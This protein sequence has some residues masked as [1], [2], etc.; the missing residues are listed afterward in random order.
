M[1]RKPWHDR[2]THTHTHTHTRKEQEREKKRDIQKT[3][4]N[5]FFFSVTLSSEVSENELKTESGLLKS[6]KPPL[7][8][9]F[10]P[11][12][13]NKQTKNQN[14][15]KINPNIKRVKKNFILTWFAFLFIS[16][17]FFFFFLLF[18]PLRL[19]LEIHTLS[20]DTSPL[21]PFLCTH[22]NIMHTHTR[23]HTHAHTHAYSSR[24]SRNLLIF[25]ANAVEFLKDHRHNSTHT[26]TKKKKMG[27]WGCNSKPN[28]TGKN[29][30]ETRLFFGQNIFQ[31]TN[32][33]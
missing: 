6:E 2:I 8:S 18:P 16:H 29:A 3:N 24:D 32:F 13:Y 25:E 4:T 26:H 27:W 19:A 21:S 23:T 28:C 17:V 31:L 12:K 33:I 14:K 1:L 9:V 11:I 20:I 30:K 7:Q 10:P 15:K 22:V 5:I